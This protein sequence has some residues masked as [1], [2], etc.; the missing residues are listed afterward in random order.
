MPDTLSTTAT[1][2]AQAR[3]AFARGVTKP[4][5]WR[6][7]QLRALRLMLVEHEAEIAQALCDD[8]G[9]S[10]TEAWVTE[11]GFVVAFGVLGAYLPELFEPRVRCTG[12]TIGYNLGGVLGG[13]V[14]PVVATHLARGGG[15]PWGVAAWL[16]GMSLLSVGC[17]VLLPET[18]TYSAAAPEPAAAPA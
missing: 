18:R 12:A 1:A 11:I 7:E 4:Y 9:K 5:E 3:D 6:V 17:Y 16:A 10:P 15:V 13:G 2:V 8:L 14:T